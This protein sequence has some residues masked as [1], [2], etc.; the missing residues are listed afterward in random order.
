MSELKTREEI[1]HQYKWRLEDLFPSEEAWEQ[2]LKRLEE[3]VPEARALRVS[4]IIW[5]AFWRCFA[6]LMKYPF[7]W[8]VYLF[9]HA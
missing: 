2:E 7:R 8:S 6:L 3:I 9:M 1:A 5:K 4:L